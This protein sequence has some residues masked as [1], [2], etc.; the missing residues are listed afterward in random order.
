M[1]DFFDRL[2][3]ELTRAATAPTHP[4]QATAERRRVQRWPIFGSAAAAL[5]ASIV[6]VVALLS[7]GAPA[8]L[9]NWTAVPTPVSSSALAAAITKCYG[10][11]ASSRDLGQRVLVE[12]RGRSTAAIFIKN[13]T[14]YMCRYD[15]AA[16]AETNDSM[17]PLRSAPGPDQLSV[18]YETQGGG[19]SG[20]LPKKLG[21]E[22]RKR[23]RTRAI[24]LALREFEIGD[25]YGFWALGRAGSSVSAVRFAFAGHPAVTATI[26]NGWYFA[27]WPWTTD[28]TS[29]TVSTRTGTTTSPMANSH[30]NAIR[31]VGPTPACQPGSPGC[32]FGVTSP[33]PQKTST[34]TG[35]A[36]STARQCQALSLQSQGLPADAFEGKATV[37][38]THGIYSAIIHVTDNRLFGCFIGGSQ[39]NVHGSYHESLASFGRVQ[40]TPEPRHISAPYTVQTGTSSGRGGPGLGNAKHPSP[41]QIR[42]LQQRSRGGGYGPYAIGQAA[43]DV[44]AVTFTF[45]NGRSVPATVADGWYFA[46]WPETTTPTSVTVTTSTG[47]STS[48]LIA[49]SIPRVS[50][51][52]GCQPSTAGCVFARASP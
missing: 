4:V 49:S 29:V 1:P 47:T 20:H 6:A 8:A 45:A 7:S 13:G 39:K 9:A 52:P 33:V 12:A 43:S 27:W 19:G 11:N 36:L 51:I 17:G 25:G 46:W 14:V 38:E 41:A 3:G 26:Q 40:N 18:P 37:S 30:L 21:R 5:T 16:P 31:G 32:V 23:P 42:A 15:S 28:P 35:V 22:L 24:G 50:V 34:T 10:V 48:P 2:G 44:S